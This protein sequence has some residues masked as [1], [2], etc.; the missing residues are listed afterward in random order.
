MSFITNMSIARR[1]FFAVA[2]AALIPAIIIA[3]LGGS[4][5]STLNSVNETVQKSDDAVKLATDQQ[6]DLLR[7]NALLAAAGPTN[8]NSF[9]EN[10]QISQEVSSL[11]GDFNKKLALYT[12]N[13][14]ITTSDNM[15]SVRDVL[16]NNGLGLQVPVSQHSMIFIVALQWH[17]YESS[18][19]VVLQDLQQKA[20]LGKLSDDL[21][22]ANLFY[23][24]L[25]GN[26]DN[27]VGLT[28][29]IS[30]SIAQVNASQTTT[31]LIGTI[32]AFFLSTLVVFA[33]GYVVNL[34]ITRPLRQLAVLT[35]RISKGETNVRAAIGGHDEIYLVASSMNQM[36]DN[37]VHLMQETRFQHDILKSRVEQLISEVSGI[38]GGDLSIKANVTADALGVLADSFNYM[39]RELAS[40][41][42]RVK[43]VAREVEKLT[44]TTLN[45]MT[46]L[47][48]IGD[49]QIE[50]MAA[51]AG[52]VEQMADETRQV[53]ERA[54]VLSNIA[55]E[56]RQTAQGGRNAVQQVVAGMG[57]IHENMQLTAGQVQLLGE[58]S[59]EITNI[60]TVISNIAYQT[61][62]LALDA[63]VQS[64][65]A[66]ANGKAFGAIASDI[67]RLAEQTKQQA[68]MIAHIVRT[69]NEHISGASV[70][71]RDTERETAA[72]TKLGHDAGKALEL[73]FAAVEQQAREIASID[74]MAAHQLDASKAVVH[75][76]QNMS[77]ATRHSSASTRDAS[78]NMW[79]L[80]H[81][82]KQLRTSVEAFKL[83]NEQARYVDR[84][85]GSL[86]EPSS[87]HTSGL[88]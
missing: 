29:S 38:G 2:M 40:L 19:N 39:V 25:K 6:A 45:R 37:I 36:L 61:N 55:L 74:K 67:R 50:Q 73:I 32:F 64:A 44:A 14:Q 15:K 8:P 82:V 87:P 20:G 62:R 51:T 49:R 88:R 18:Q 26:L 9:S 12:Q 63:A 83:P 78:Q 72:G 71:M 52:E 84:H 65:M 5:I 70:S 58:S 43:M 1:L 68:G 3:V 34:T 76:M 81:L 59:K 24:P 80:A 41:V 31:I 35:R 17:E 33:I 21:A 30:Q 69:V 10:V 86:R 57:R 53:A 13:Y 85:S 4:Y 28:E 42:I 60:V 22:N 66:G 27:L 54:R 77:E 75:S 46:S 79:R 47:V 16:Q 23:L 48:E 11:T 7:M 56:T